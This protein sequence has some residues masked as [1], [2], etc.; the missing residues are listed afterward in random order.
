MAKNPKSNLYFVGVFIFV[1]INVMKSTIYIF[2]FVFL[3]VIAGGAC[4]GN[5]SADES[6]RQDY[7]DSG[8]TD[9]SILGTWQLLTVLTIEGADSLLNDYTQGVKG[10]KMFNETHFAF[11]QHDLNQGKEKDSLYVSGGGPYTYKDGVYTE[12]LEYC[13]FRVYENNSFEFELFVT[14][15]TLVQKGTEELA[16]AGVNKYIIETYVRVK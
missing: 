7:A 16:E 10:I 14:G 1:Q 2:L 5:S 11:F 9:S 13:N 15:D 12:H 4:T 3:L 6:T 8:K